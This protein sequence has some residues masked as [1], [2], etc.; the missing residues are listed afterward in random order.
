MSKISSS[1]EF[2][3]K[4][5]AGELGRKSKFSNYYTLRYNDA[6]F[7]M[8]YGGVPGWYN[9]E[10]PAIL[11]IR[12]GK[13][14]IINT[15]NEMDD[16][17]ASYRRGHSSASFRNLE[18]Y[19]KGKAAR[20]ITEWRIIDNHLHSQL[21]EIGGKIFLLDYPP[22]Q[23]PSTAPF[24]LDMKDLVTNKHHSVKEMMQIKGTFSSVQEARS[25]LIPE[26]AQNDGTL[27]YS[28][29]AI[30]PPTGVEFEIDFKTR[31]QAMNWPCPV[32]W[33]IPRNFIVTDQRRLVITENDL[34]TLDTATERKIREF[35]AQERKTA[36]AVR[37]I[38]RRYEVSGNFR[39][40]R[41]VHQGFWNNHESESCYVRY[42]I[43]ETPIVDVGQE[44]RE[45]IWLDTYGVI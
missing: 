10:Y 16:M 13:E 39:S 1:S 34:R 24:Y 17:L 26:K 42:G 18:G 33:E 20:D 40:L 29:C 45:I 25:K 32:G 38:N 6:E 35:L 44:W 12:S 11:A 4:W 22:G 41:F 7:L 8:Y 37:E 15:D 23:L 21:I 3:R 28:G 19:S 2:I 5:F 9:D 30:L 14:I 31:M 43:G 36:A 27:L